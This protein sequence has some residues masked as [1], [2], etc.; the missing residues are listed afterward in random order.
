M[1]SPW[2]NPQGAWGRLFRVLLP[3]LGLLG[4]LFSGAIVALPYVGGVVIV[5]VWCAWLCSAVHVLQHRSDNRRRGEPYPNTLMRDQNRF[6]AREG[7]RPQLASRQDHHSLPNLDWHAA[8]ARFA[9]LRTEY[10]Q[11]ECDPLAVLRLPALTDVSVASTGRFVDAFAEAQ[12]LDTETE[13][14]GVHC[15]RFAGAVDQAWRCWHAARDA[16][17][18]IR[19]SNIPANERVIVRRA[20]KLL[21]MA[22]ESNHDAERAAAYAKARMELAKL[23]RSGTLPLPPAA[24]VALGVAIR[25][26]LPSGR[27]EG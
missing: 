26:Q 11:F 16:A 22:R 7:Q 9:Q 27:T 24:T 4:V 8:R 15:A 12:A 5:V 14:P 1:G 13:P 18:R 21:T 25:S 20:I 23:E 17:E 2:R 10:A 3:L 19:L 6:P